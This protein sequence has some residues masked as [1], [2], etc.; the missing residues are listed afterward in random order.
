MGLASGYTVLAQSANSPLAN[1]ALDDTRTSI[2]P[3]SEERAAAQDF[4]QNVNEARINLTMQQVD[5]ARQKIIMARNLIPII[6]GLRR[7][8]AV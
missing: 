4:I 1:N 6:S 7:S 5:L 2:L 8:R 3:F